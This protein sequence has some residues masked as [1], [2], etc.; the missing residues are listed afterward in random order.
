MFRPLIPLLAAAFC[1]ALAPLAS[2][3]PLS[4][5]GPLVLES[6]DMVVL[7]GDTFVERDGKYGY[8]EAAL[9]AARTSSSPMP[10]L[11][12]A[13]G[14][15]SMRTAGR[16]APFNSTLPTPGTCDSFCCRMLLAWS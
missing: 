4:V 5:E 12:S 9:T 3:R 6:G 11:K 8:L 16:D 10:Y 15:N 13:R 7:L 14:F 2:A 1:G